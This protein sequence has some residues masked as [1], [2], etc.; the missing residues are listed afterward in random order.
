MANYYVSSVKWAAFTLWAASTAYTVGQIVKRPGST[1]VRVYRCEVAGTSG[2]SEP[3]WSTTSNSTTTDNGITWRCIT[4][5]PAYGWDG[6]GD[7]INNLRAIVTATNVDVFFVDSTHNEDGTTVNAGDAQAI[8]VNAAGSVP[9]VKADYQRGAV[10]RKTTTGTL[11]ILGGHYQ[12]IDFIADT[13]SASGSINVSNGNQGNT[14]SDCLLYLKNTNSSSSI[15]LSATLGGFAEW[16]NNTK[17]RF[18]GH[19]GQFINNSNVGL[20]WSNS[21]ASDTISSDGVMPV[22]LFN[23]SGAY[24][25]GTINCR[26][27]DLSGFTG[28]RLLASTAS[29]NF[30]FEDCLLADGVALTNNN[31]GEIGLDGANIKFIN[32][33]RVTNPT[34]QSM[35]AYEVVYAKDFTTACVL[36]DTP[37]FGSGKQAERSR[38][39]MTN[40]YGFASRGLVLKKWN[41]STSAVTAKVRGVYFGPTLPDK[42]HFFLECSYPKDANNSLTKSVVDVSRRLDTTATDTTTDDWTSGAAA[43]QNSTS[44]IRGDF[45][46]VASNPGKIFIAD[47]AVA[48]TSAASEPAAF[49]TANYGDTITDNGVTWL[50]GIPFKVEAQFTAARAGFVRGQVR[51]L[52]ASTTGYYVVLNPKLEIA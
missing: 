51:L 7:T 50:C 29:H 9:P 13:G 32:C 21:D 3:S 22:S 42:G 5:M 20:T 41:N 11:N 23:I 30:L 43:R 8:S 48:Q 31:A 28:T 47:N 44:Y 1:N 46:K 16:T 52:P 39:T 2:A 40:S 26:G 4:G 14:L 35:T 15:T 19:T 6:C 12:G 25:G 27:L 34:K 18:G 17:V 37:D 10:C 36:S 38:I 49:A 45:V 33:S 24:N